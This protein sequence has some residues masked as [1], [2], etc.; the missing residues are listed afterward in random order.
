M[1]KGFKACGRLMYVLGGFSRFVEVCEQVRQ[2]PGKN[3][4][5]AAIAGY[6]P[7]L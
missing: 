2:T 7:E 5:V 1:C 6:L 4:K 3:A